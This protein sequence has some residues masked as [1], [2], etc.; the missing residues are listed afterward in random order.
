MC[1]CGLCGRCLCV[2]DETNLFIKRGY[3]FSACPFNVYASYQRMSLISVTRPYS[4]RYMNA[5]RLLVFSVF[6]CLHAWQM[7][8]NSNSRLTS[9]VIHNLATTWHASHDFISSI[10]PFAWLS[11]IYRWCSMCVRVPSLTMY[12]RKWSQSCAP[13]ISTTRAA[14]RELPVWVTGGIETEE[15]KVCK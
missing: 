1:A 7:C 4:F 10:L 11:C 6:L 2:C 13:R 3:V 14:K 5:V 8:N 15:G 9:F 12:C